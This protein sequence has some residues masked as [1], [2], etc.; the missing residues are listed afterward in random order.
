M[1]RTHAGL[2]VLCGLSLLGFV[3]FAGSS[4]AQVL[5][6]KQ[7][8]CPAHTWLATIRTPYYGEIW[9]AFPV[10]SGARTLFNGNQAQAF[11]DLCGRA[12]S[13]WTSNSEILPHDQIGGSFDFRWT[14][15]TQSQIQGASNKRDNIP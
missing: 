9:Y 15:A 8:A 4:S 10:P 14:W 1:H 3:A 7:L 6:G 2:A 5:C 13:T 12:I 11:S